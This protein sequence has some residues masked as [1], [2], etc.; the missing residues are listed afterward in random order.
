VRAPLLLGLLLALAAPAAAQLDP[1]PRASRVGLT[2]FSGVRVPYNTGFLTLLDRDGE[3][4]F[5]ATEQRG[6]NAL[7][8]ADAEI[9]V[10]GPLSLLV[11]GVFTQTGNSDFFV[12]RSPG[13]GD[14]IDFRVRFSDETLFARAGASVRFQAPRLPGQTRPSPATDL[15]AAAGL[16]RRLETNHPAVNFGFKGAFPLNE[17]GL[18]FVV[19]VEDYFVFWDHDAL[20]P[21]M[22]DLL[23]PSE[24]P[25]RVD[26]LYDT[27]NVLLLRAGL[28]LRF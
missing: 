16:V 19:G 28:S 14:S 23:R 1:A 21:V 13:F 8:G 9:R 20:E 11:G 3:P 25:V 22:A 17:A 6:G 5:S 24:A 10:A 4:I 18:E 2:V 27:S 7:L 26:F 12:D 15:F